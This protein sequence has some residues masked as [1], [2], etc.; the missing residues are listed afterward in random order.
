M[1]GIAVTG[2]ASGIGAATRALL[3]ADGQRVI[4]VDLRDAEVE[5]DLGTAPG[6]AE[7][8]AAVLAACDGTLDGYAGFAGVPATVEPP[9]L[10]VN[11]SY[12]GSTAMLDGLRPALARGGST[13]AVAVSSCAA[14]VAPVD[15]ALVDACLAGDESAAAALEVRGG[16]AYASVKLAL[17][18]WVRRN[19]PAWAADGVRLNAL[20]PGNTRTPLTKVTLD[21]PELGPLMR[22]VPV[23]VGHWAEPNEIAAAARWMLSEGSSFMV[24]SVLFVDGGTD[25]LVRPDKF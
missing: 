4:G 12:F 7:A 3:E 10:L 13:S 19:A 17:G 25:A 16:V 1:A 24:G 21:D 20:A 23:P 9:S 6:R 18:R 2:S 15:D 22:E 14:T 8:V 11:V 5:A